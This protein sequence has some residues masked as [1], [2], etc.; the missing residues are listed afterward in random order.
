M[1]IVLLGPGGVETKIV[2]DDGSGLQKSFL[3][4]TNVKNI[5]GKPA[6]EIIKETDANI[7]KLQRERVTFENN[8]KN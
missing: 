7:R 1:D 4:K 3:N 8:Q 5:L 6:E 2:L